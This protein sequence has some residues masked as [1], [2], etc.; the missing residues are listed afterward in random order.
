M[1]K[2]KQQQKKQQQQPKQSAQ[3]LL[4]SFGAKIGSKEV[5]KFERKFPDTPLK[6]VVKYDKKK[7][8]VRLKP[9]ARKYI[10]GKGVNVPGFIPPDNGGD[11]RPVDDG[12]GIFGIMQGAQESLANIIGGYDV[13]T[14]QIG[15]D[16]T[17]KSASIRGEA[18]K[19]VADAY[20]GAQRYG[21]DRDLEGTKYS[22]DKESEWRQAVA[23]N[24]VKGRLDLQ[25]IINAG[26]EKVSNIE[27]QASRDVAD[28][29]GK[30]GVE[31][32]KTRGEFDEK[33]GK[34]NLAGGMYGLI[35][36]AFG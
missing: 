22:A 24:E 7:K 25:P 27:A 34:I 4:K 23:G 17:T 1:T 20:A 28:I 3:K 16:A 8:D 5:Q 29:T 15:A 14:A 18:D 30:Y 12:T 32:I 13:Q 10:S 2:K 9:S 21:S 33:I 36:S 6:R 31:G 11:T 35:S 26:L 19:Y